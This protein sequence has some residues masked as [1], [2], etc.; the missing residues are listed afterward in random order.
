MTDLLPAIKGGT[1]GDRGVYFMKGGY[2][3]P[4]GWKPANP[5]PAVQKA[6]RGDDDHAAYADSHL[7]ES[8]VAT[9]V[10]AIAK[11]PYWNDSAIVITWDDSEGSYDHVPPPQYGHCPDNRNCGDG[12][13]VPLIVISPFARTHAVVRDVGDHASFVKFLDVLFD[14]PPLATLPDEKQYMPRGPRDTAALLTDLTGAFDPDRLAGRTPPVPASEAIIPDDVVNTFPP[15][16]SCSSLN[17][18]PVDVPRR[19]GDAAARLF[20]A[21]APLALRRR[22]FGGGRRRGG[23]GWRG[24][25]AAHPRPPRRPVGEAHADDR[26]HGVLTAGLIVGIDVEGERVTHLRAARERARVV[27]EAADGLAALVV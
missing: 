14:L 12:P 4:F 22:R 20:A 2:V 15:K 19:V 26:T 24:H 18:K 10:N 9:M 21:T 7:S 3:N 1:L 11:S 13:R 16:M 8:L 17:I 6:F 5:D 25:D 27:D 23:R